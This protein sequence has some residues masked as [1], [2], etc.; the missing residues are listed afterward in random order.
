MDFE[1]VEKFKNILRMIADKKPANYGVLLEAFRNHADEAIV[2]KLA[3][4]D[5]LIPDD[6]T[7]AEFCDALNGLLKQA[8]EAGIAR[9]LAKAQSE[10]LDTQ[11][12]ETLVKLLAN[13]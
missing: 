13:K 6:G 11:E 7:E 10:G 5:L 2:N 1:G 3:S 9:L 12:Q 8:R 4:F